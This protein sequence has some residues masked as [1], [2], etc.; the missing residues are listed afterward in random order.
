MG[1]VESWP[2]P[3]IEHPGNVPSPFSPGSTDEGNSA[4]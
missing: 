2:E 4:V 3:L 1:T